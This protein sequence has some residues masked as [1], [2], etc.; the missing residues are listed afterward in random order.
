MD[1]DPDD[2]DAIRDRLTPEQRR[3]FDE[4]QASGGDLRPHRHTPDEHER[5]AAAVRA[6]YSQATEV[7]TFWDLTDQVAADEGRDVHEAAGMVMCAARAKVVDIKFDAALGWNRFG[8][9]L[10]HE[11][12]RDQIAWTRHNTAFL[13]HEGDQ[14]S[15]AL[16][17]GWADLAEQFN[18]EQIEY[19]RGTFNTISDTIRDQV[20]PEHYEEAAAGLLEALAPTITAGL[21]QRAA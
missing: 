20:R 18:P 12:L 3:V 17:D 19:L 21:A 9:D 8:R 14:L 15:A 7:P 13:T 16:R 6:W 1:M 10:V 2:L 5:V 11:F 4:L